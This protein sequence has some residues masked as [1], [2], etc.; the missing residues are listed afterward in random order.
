MGRPPLRGDNARTVTLLS[1][2]ISSA[3]RTIGKEPATTPFTIDLLPDASKIF[4]TTE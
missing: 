3:S 4:I 1:L 2:K